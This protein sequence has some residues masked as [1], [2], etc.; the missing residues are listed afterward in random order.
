[1]SSASANSSKKIASFEKE[2][3]KIKIC[4]GPFKAVLNDK[5]Y[6]LKMDPEY[7]KDDSVEMMELAIPVS[8]YTKTFD[9][10][11]KITK[12]TDN[13]TGIEYVLDKDSVIKA[14]KSSK[15]KKSDKSMAEK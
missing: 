13:K 7:A 2:V 1:M 9:E 15:Q 8:T 11:G 14:T 4:M 3:E 5:E 12:R 6:M 10:N